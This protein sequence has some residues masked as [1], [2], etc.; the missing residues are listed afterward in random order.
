M[1][2]GGSETDVHGIHPALVPHCFGEHP[3]I[4]AGPGTDVSDDHAG[5]H[6]AGGNQFFSVMENF[7]TFYFEFLQP[8]FHLE[9]G[10]E[11]VSVD[12]RTGARFSCR[13]FLGERCHTPQCEQ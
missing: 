7:A 3:G 2:A 4:K 13:S 12:P 9:V 6:A 11:E 5:L 10:I 8:F 1:E